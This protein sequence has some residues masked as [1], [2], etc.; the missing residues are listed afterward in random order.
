M[1]V[2]ITDAEVWAATG[3]NGGG[4]DAPVGIRRC[5]ANRNGNC[6]END[7]Q[8]KFA[9]SLTPFFCGKDYETELRISQD[10][11]AATASVRMT[12]TQGFGWKVGI[13]VVKKADRCARDDTCLDDP[14][15]NGPARVGD[16]C[17]TR[18]V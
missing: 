3:L 12:G 15:G 14:V 7:Q 10:A 2:E 4:I 11:F 9:H 8:C 1:R 5:V 16:P 6:G 17:H 18:V 13:W